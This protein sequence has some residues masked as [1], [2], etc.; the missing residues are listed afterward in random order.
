MAKK[1]GASGYVEGDNVHSGSGSKGKGK[2]IG[3]PKVSGGDA[4]ASA[5]EKTHNATFA[6][7]G[8]TKMSGEQAAESETENGQAGH[9]ADPTADDNAPG[10]KFATGGSG[11]MFGFNPS[12][13]AQSGITSA[14]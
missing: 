11:K 5:T 2:S 14:R 9:T 10:K 13:P 7:G 4:G 3:A 1:G 8:K 12:V 6:V